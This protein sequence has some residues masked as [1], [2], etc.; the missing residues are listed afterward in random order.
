MKKKSLIYGLIACLGFSAVSC[1]DMLSP[2]SERHSYEVAQDTMYSYWGIV[3]SMQNI[4][5][6]YVLLGE[7]RGDLV[8]GTYYLSD[9][10]ENILNYDMASATDGSNRYLKAADYY[11]VINSCNAY[12][13]SYD[14]TRTT[15]TLT[16]YMKKE[17]AQV[18]AIRAWTYLQLVQ[19]YGKVP[20]STER[21][22]R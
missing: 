7:L 8:R 9:S 14:S 18:S 5:E 1:E 12:L 10:I 13:A 6:R 11:H 19:V 2:D 3:R 20:F 22:R 17:A 16:P 21:P 15:G 4:A